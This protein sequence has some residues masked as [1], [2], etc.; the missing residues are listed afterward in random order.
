MIKLTHTQGIFVYNSNKNFPCSED[1]IFCHVL[2]YTEYSGGRITYFM[3]N[4]NNP[5]FPT[6]TVDS[7]TNEQRIGLIEKAI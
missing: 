1:K 5:R 7:T 4:L 3:R 6:W 2:L